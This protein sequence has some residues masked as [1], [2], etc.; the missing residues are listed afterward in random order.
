MHRRSFLSLAAG[1]VS[2]A[3]LGQPYTPASAAAA[4]EPSPFIQPVLSHQD[5]TGDLHRMPYSTLAFKVL[6][7][8]TQG[9]MFAMEHHNLRKGGPPRHVHPHQDEWFYVLEGDYIAEVGDKRV[10]LNPGDSALGPRGIPHVW[11]CVGGGTGRLIITFTPAGK[12]EDLF[13]YMAQNPHAT[14]MSAD[15]FR[16]HDMELLGPPLAV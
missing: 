9:A 2:A 10:S 15:L 13:K 11:A 14:L 8:D 6:T 7:A 5:R 3:A 16:E 1:T 4:Q 12:M